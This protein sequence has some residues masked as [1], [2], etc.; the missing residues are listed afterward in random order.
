MQNVIIPWSDNWWIEKDRAWFCAGEI[1]ALFCID[2]NSLECELVG[3]IPDCDTKNFR[4]YPYCIKYKNK[5]LCLP[6]LGKD[7]WYYNL[8]QKSWRKIEIGNIERVMTSY[9]ACMQDDRRIWLL[10]EKRGR[11]FAINIEEEILETEYYLSD[12]EDNDFF[13]GYVCVQNN[14]Y[15]LIKDKMYCLD[16]NS[17]NISIHK[18]DGAEGGLYSLSYDGFNFWLSG[19][20]NEIYVWNPQEGNV[21]VVELPLKQSYLFSQQPAFCAT[22]VMGKYIWCIPFQVSEIIYIDIETYEVASLEIEEEQQAK[23]SIEDNLIDHKYLFEYIRENR[24][25]GLY[26]L[27]N[28]WIFE[29]DTIDLCAR[30]KTYTLSDTTMQTL[31]TAFSRDK[32][33]LNENNNLEKMFFPMLLKKDEEKQKE[34]Y[35]NA[36]EAIFNKIKNM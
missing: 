13:G 1:G 31:F 14:L 8:D 18:I 4:L 9:M 32:I 22:V 17:G 24:Y 7:I 35:Y 15:Y 11:V 2:M 26:S 19:C 36:G 27:K 10:E 20:C 34:I 3:W 21:R 28:Q 16:M 25:I 29:I 33:A 5:V 12:L 23:E 6:A 30:R